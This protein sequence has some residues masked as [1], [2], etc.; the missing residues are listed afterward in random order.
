MSKFYK[1]VIAMFNVTQMFSYVYKYKLIFIHPW[2]SKNLCYIY[3]IFYLLLTVID[4][5]ILK[6]GLKQCVLLYNEIF[7]YVNKQ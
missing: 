7:V 1:Y 3:H 4:E 5:N 2:P 6:I